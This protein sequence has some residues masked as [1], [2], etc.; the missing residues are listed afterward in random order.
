[1]DRF[2][3][4]SYEPTVSPGIDLPEISLYEMFKRSV[5]RYPRHKAVSFMG[6]EFTYQEL[7]AMIDAFATALES[8]G[9]KKGDRVAIHLP[10]CTQFPIAFYGA[11]AIGA[12][13]V[14]CNVMYVAR[15]LIYQLNDSG[16]A[17]IVTLTRFYKLV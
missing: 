2:W 10:N 5:E 11:M 8:L 1:M 17:T 7:L 16:A 9:V 6:R 15:E 14:P 4:K 3:L 13:A 12:I